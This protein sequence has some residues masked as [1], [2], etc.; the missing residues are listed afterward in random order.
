MAI[1]LKAG[2]LSI[3]LPSCNK[4]SMITIVVHNSL[5]LQIDEFNASSIVAIQ[6]G[7]IKFL[8]SSNGVATL[9]AHGR[10]L[11]VD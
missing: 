9:E 4:Q 10:R 3:S 2:V 5:Q 7:H 11:L 6:D 1:L 8:D